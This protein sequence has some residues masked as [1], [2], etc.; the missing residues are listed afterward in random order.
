MFRA[1][2]HASFGRIE[3]LDRVIE[4]PPCR[5]TLV[6]SRE[7]GAIRQFAMSTAV[8]LEGDV[9]DRFGAT[10]TKS[11][12]SGRFSPSGNGAHRA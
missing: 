4:E 2:D 9:R 8:V 11:S 7:L 10:L 1:C 3:A 6:L 12:V 5:A